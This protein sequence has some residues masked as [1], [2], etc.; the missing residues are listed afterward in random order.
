MSGNRNVVGARFGKAAV[1]IIYPVPLYDF[2]LR[3]LV[4]TRTLYPSV[5]ASPKPVVINQ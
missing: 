5:I 4:L 3:R 2:C 1:R